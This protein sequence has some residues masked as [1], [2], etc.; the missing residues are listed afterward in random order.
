MAAFEKVTEMSYGKVCRKQFTIKRRV[1][2]L[3]WGLQFPAEKPE[4]TS[5]TIGSLF[6][7]STDSYDGGIDSKR[8]RSI[9]HRVDKERGVSE[10]VHRGGKRVLHFRCHTRDARPLRPARAGALGR[11]FPPQVER[12]DDRNV[13]SS[14][15]LGGL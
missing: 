4:G 15:T 3:S 14:G 5:D 10:G 13:S 1:F 7:D 9:F 2:G 11:V 6:K 12:N 8:S